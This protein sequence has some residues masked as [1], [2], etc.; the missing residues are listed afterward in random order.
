MWFGSVDMIKNVTK[1][2]KSNKSDVYELCPGTM[3]SRSHPGRTKTEH[4]ALE[5]II[6]TGN[7]VIVGIWKEATY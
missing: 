4:L 6:Q 5:F 7:S 2:Q 3:Q 1:P